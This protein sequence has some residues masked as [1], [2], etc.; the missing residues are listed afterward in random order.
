MISDIMVLW[1]AVGLLC[2]VCWFS[3]RLLSDIWARRSNSFTVLGLIKHQFHAKL[4]FRSK[5]NQWLCSL[6]VMSCYTWHFFP[7]AED[8]SKAVEEAMRRVREDTRISVESQGQ[9]KFSVWVSFIEVYNEQIFDL[10]EPIRSKKKNARRVVMQLKED[11][12]G[13]PF[14]RGNRMK[15]YLCNIY[16]DCQV[17]ISTTFH[18]HILNTYKYYSRTLC[19]MCCRY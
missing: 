1:S 2:G 3:F 9:V 15:F 6:L 18:I 14:V 11:R 16:T 13:V 7:E 8:F 10:L 5:L 19:T 4:G 12:N 17:G